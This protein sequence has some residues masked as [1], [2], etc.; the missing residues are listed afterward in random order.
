VGAAACVP[1]AVVARRRRIREAARV[2]LRD[3]HVRGRAG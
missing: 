1:V 3:R 2:Q